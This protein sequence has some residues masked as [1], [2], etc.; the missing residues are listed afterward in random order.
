METHHISSGHLT[1]NRVEQ[2]LKNNIKL[3]LSDDAKA[4]ITRCREYLNRKMET[5][6]EPS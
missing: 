4:R 2:I 1:I 3:A 6:K 5:Q